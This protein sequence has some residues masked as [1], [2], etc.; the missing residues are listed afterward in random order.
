[1]IFA[2]FVKY[3]EE[4]TEFQTKLITYLT[5]QGQISKRLVELNEQGQ[6]LYGGMMFLGAVEDLEAYQ[7]LVEQV[8][9]KY[10]ELGE[11]SQLIAN[12][13]DE[14][15]EVAEQLMKGLKDE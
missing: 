8:N 4:F 11:S 14:M 9:I 13:L 10:Q 6:E 3:L 7:A 15:G 2:D 1:M 5:R 12:A